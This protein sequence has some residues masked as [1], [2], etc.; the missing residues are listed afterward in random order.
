M[1][2]SNLV[3]QVINSLEN[4]KSPFIYFILTFFFVVTL[5]N[6]IEILSTHCPISLSDFT[7]YYLLYIS[8]AMSLILLFHIAT[9]TGI[10]KVSR[11]ILPSFIILNL[12]PLLDLVISRGKGYGM[13]YML[14]GVH[15][16]LILRFFTFF[17]NFHGYG[18]T[19]G[20][21]IE[22]S[23][24]LLGCFIYFHIDLLLTIRASH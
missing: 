14:P 12:A 9:R 13:T 18:V 11:V 15:D 16:N 21:R 10:M 3:E 2:L 20:I 19:P 5:R 24:V 22:I 17:G 7:H 6:F 8:L 23:L 1:K 4:P